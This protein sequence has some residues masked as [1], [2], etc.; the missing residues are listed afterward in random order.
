MENNEETEVLK[1]CCGLAIG[2][3]I[4]G[5]LLILLF[6]FIEII[7]TKYFLL[8]FFGGPIALFIWAAM[9]DNPK[10][11]PLDPSG[12]SKVRECQEKLQRIEEEVKKN[13][14]KDKY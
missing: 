11:Y 1:V 6:K 2:G 8:L 12:G 4:C 7:G 14:S 10:N 13:A 5:G 3:L 9:K